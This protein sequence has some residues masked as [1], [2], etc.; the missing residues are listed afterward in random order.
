MGRIKKRETKNKRNLKTISYTILIAF[1]IISFWRGI[2]GLMDLYL[3]PNNHTLS[4]GISV[5]IGLIVLYITKH[6]IGELA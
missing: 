2:W 3:F 4:L 1:A 6:I 5:L